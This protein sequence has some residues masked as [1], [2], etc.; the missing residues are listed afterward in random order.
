MS[1]DNLVKIQTKEDNLM[2]S[3]CYIEK[4]LQILKYHNS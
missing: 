3:N 2:S 4:I 1:E